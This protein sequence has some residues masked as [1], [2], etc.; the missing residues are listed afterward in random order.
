MKNRM[1]L[2]FRGMSVTVLAVTLLVMGCS[3]STAVKPAADKIVAPGP[4][5][6]TPKGGMPQEGIKVHGHWTIEVRN[7]DGTVA[8]VREFENA[9]TGP[10]GA[11]LSKF[12]GRANSV[13]GWTILLSSNNVSSGPFQID[14]IEY[15][16][17]IVENGGLNAPS[18]AGYFPSLTVAAPSIG[19]NADKLVLSGTATAQFNGSIRSVST[20]VHMRP[21][22]EAPSSTYGGG[23]NPTL[24]TTDL[25]TP[26]ALLAGQQ[27]LVTVV[28]SFS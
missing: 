13:G 23:G 12:M 5:A 2:L 22:T 26:V 28:I 4:A 6:S 16:G 21:N 18:G 17:M 19:T 25:G 3:G 1:Q 7:A 27:V 10:G 11:A 8:E 24:T 9:L 15:V 20:L 14:G